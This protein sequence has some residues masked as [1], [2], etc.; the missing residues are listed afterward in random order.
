MKFLE[1]PLKGSWLIQL[2]PITDDRG[3]FMRTF[4]E[5]ELQNR[6]ISFS[7]SQCNLSY[8]FKKGTLRGLHYQ[9]SPHQEAKIVWC[10][11]GVVH[12]VIVDLRKDSPTYLKSVS[13]ELSSE[14][15]QVLYIPQD[16]AHGF[17]TLTSEASLFYW[18]SAPYEKKS[19]RGIRWNDPS[20]SISWPKIDS[21]IISEQDKNF[22][23][24][25]P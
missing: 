9:S 13:F 24:F 1:T 20:L 12:D 21:L 15:N 3:S 18:M 2:E 6:G 8:N 16:F 19:S 22:P 23:D 14:R 25:K 4:C 11:S 10:Q 5:K 7:V 17:L